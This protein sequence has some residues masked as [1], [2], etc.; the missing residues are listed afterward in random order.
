M[1]AVRPGDLKWRGRERLDVERIY[2]E[3]E[4]GEEEFEEK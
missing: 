4:D 3:R 1:R 2:S